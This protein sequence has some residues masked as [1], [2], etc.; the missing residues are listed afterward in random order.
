MSGTTPVYQQQVRTT[1]P[2]GVVRSP[3]PNLAPMQQAAV[4]EPGRTITSSS[5]T[6][7]ALGAA[8]AGLGETLGGLSRQISQDQQQQN[9]ADKR[10]IQQQNIFAADEKAR[11]LPI[12]D[13]AGNLVVPDQ[14]DPLTR[15][16]R[17]FNAGI[18]QRVTADISNRGMLEAVSLRSQTENDPARFEALWQGRTRGVLESL[19]EWLRPEAE[20]TLA[21]LGA[22]HSR[23][24][25]TEAMQTERRNQ[26]QATTIRQQQLERD[27]LGLSAAGQIGTPEWQRA[28]AAYRAHINDMVRTRQIAP[29]AAP[30]I[31]ENTT[32]QTVGA[33]T[34]RAAQDA[35][36]SGRSREDVLREFDTRM[37]TQRMPLAQRERLRNV[38]EAGLNEQDAIRREARS[39]ATTAAEDWQQRIT[40]GIPVPPDE[41]MRLAAD[42]ERTG[43]PRLAQRVRDI[44]AVQQ[45]AQIYR[46]LPTADLA[47][48]A[49]EN[50]A[51][52]LR[53]DASARDVQLA[54]ITARMLAHRTEAMRAD[55]FAT[56]AATHRAAVGEVRP[57]DF[58]N[59]VALREGFQQRERQAQ[60]IATREG[61]P[62]PA[63]TAGE[64]TGLR[65]LLQEGT[66]DQQQAIL[67]GLSGPLAPNTMA[68]TL[69]QLVDGQDNAPRLQAF[70]VAAANATA[71]PPM[72]REILQGM[73]TIRQLNP[74]AV[75]GNDWKR[76]LAEEMGPVLAARP[77]TMAQVGEAARALYAQRNVTGDRPADIS[78]R[79]DD[80][81]FRTVLREIM[82]TVTFGSGL[83]S[84]GSRIP[85]PRPGMTQTQFDEHMARMPPEALAGAQAV[86]GRPFTRDMMRGAR[87]VPVDEGMVELRVN[88]FQVLDSQGRTFR[89]NLRDDWP[90]P[91]P[92]GQQQGSAEPRGIRNNNPLNLSFAGQEGAT[93]ED[94]STP[95]FARFASMEDGIA[96]SVRQI[97][98]YQRRGLTTLSQI[99]STW[100]PPNENDT[101]GYIQRVSRETG[102]NPNAAVNMRDPD[103]VAALVASMARVESGRALDPDIIRRG[104]RRAGIG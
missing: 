65:T 1:G 54:E 26:A 40:A 60:Q 43:A 67:A 46:G 47:R 35:V 22:E 88:G 96:A 84:T 2:G 49:Q 73:E 103:T 80:A 25:A 92:R 36:R 97:E 16:G 9:Q 90:A 34:V 15:E 31:L 24:I 71:R 27:L 101:P 81:K 50:A 4:L 11:I 42:L 93:M 39:E 10:E 74:A 7:G 12:R 17:V 29:E 70:V 38:V 87:M 99:V 52:L 3:G 30:V 79:L 66:I 13:A 62:I 48:K 37:D 41:G 59:P 95:R 69:N 75:Q 77:D 100:A 44:S 94:H 98:L 56:G 23:G 78:A 55:P 91:A 83:F 21:R 14:A 18:V 6:L 53:P 32:E 72:A 57:L 104:V 20:G 51:R 86:N 63:L 64:V 85:T 45:D 102:I 76:V 33:A 61:R 19:P 5:G 58:S 68:R 8:M 82:P 89:L 28:D